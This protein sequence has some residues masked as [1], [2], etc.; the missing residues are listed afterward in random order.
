MHSS[1]LKK[2]VFIFIMCPILEFLCHHL[3]VLIIMG[4]DYFAI[5]W[6]LFTSHQ[7]WSLLGFYSKTI[8]FDGQWF[9]FLSKY[10]L[11]N[12]IVHNISIFIHTWR[13]NKEEEYIIIIEITK[14]RIYPRRFKSNIQRTNNNKRI[15]MVL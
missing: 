15:I 13:L 4:I 11:L 14:H 10:L 8:M 9:E 5:A 7:L 6:F 1:I 3:H 12:S 2:Y